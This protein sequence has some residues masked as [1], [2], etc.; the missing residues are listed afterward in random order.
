MSETKTGKIT[1]ETLGKLGD[2]LRTMIPSEER[3]LF[4]GSECLAAR[5]TQRLL[6]SESGDSKL[7]KGIKLYNSGRGLDPAEV[8]WRYE[9]VDLVVNAKKIAQQCRYEEIDLDNMIGEEI[10]KI[11]RQADLVDITQ[12]STDLF[13]ATRNQFKKI[14]RAYRDNSPLP[15]EYDKLIDLVVRK[16][17]QAATTEM[18]RVREEEDKAAKAHA[19]KRD[20]HRELVK[21]QRERA[22][23]TKTLISGKIG[24]DKENKI[25][26]AIV[27]KTLVFEKK[28]DS[29]REEL[30]IKSAKSKL[31][32]SFEELKQKINGGL[33]FGEDF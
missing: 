12:T 6:K 26:E 23:E 3:S 22:Q 16:Q 4:F 14:E 2:I 29:A 20:R 33:K 27:K 28:L 18:D 30:E 1:P 31:T 13:N 9:T 21:D 5:S 25:F 17:W 10:K 15:G 11:E 8:I 7:S 32:A 19:T 24:H